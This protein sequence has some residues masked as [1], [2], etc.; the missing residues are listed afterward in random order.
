MV[1]EGGAGPMFAAEVGREVGTPKVLVPPHPG[2]SA[3]IGLLATDL[4][5]EYSATHYQDISTLEAERLD[6]A[7]RELEERAT[8]QLR[9]DGI[10]AEDVRLER[11][12][13]CRYEGQGY[14]LRIPVPPGPVDQ[15]WEE[16]VKA[17][18]HEAH[19]RAFARRDEEADV[20]VVNLR[21]QGIGS[22]PE[23]S[24]PG[25]ESGGSEPPEDALGG[26]RE[27]WFAVDDSL[28]KVQVPLYERSRLKAGTRIAGPAIVNQ[29]D[30][31]TIIP[32][33]MDADIDRHGN[34]IIDC[35]SAAPETAGGVT[36]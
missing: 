16:Q 24:I 33:G 29:F 25:V 30:T 18:F 13:D 11:L 34:L 21:A 19:E 10:A 27:A 17:S 20:Q 22:M 6:D 28:Q 23:L 32:A 31:T 15:A 1:A 35:A 36:A 3:A 7:Y 12:A 9:E 5:Y 2:L 26:H 8:E 4:V 14:E